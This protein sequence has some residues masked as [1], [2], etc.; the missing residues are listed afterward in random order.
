MAINQWYDIPTL[1]SV[2]VIESKSLLFPN[3]VLIDTLS[4]RV[5]N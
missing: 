4:E 2:L 1:L 3:H 5:T